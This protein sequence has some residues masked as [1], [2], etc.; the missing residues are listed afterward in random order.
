MTTATVA[1]KGK[2]VG[3]FKVGA[4]LP[5]V[6]PGETVLAVPLSHAVRQAAATR[7]GAKLCFTFQGTCDRLGEL[8]GVEGGEEPEDAWEAVLLD[9]DTQ[10]WVAH[11]Y[12]SCATEGFRHTDCVGHAQ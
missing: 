5:D 1:L 4:L 2:R 3:T 7:R 9:A 6:F 12:Q 10:W 8:L 11:R